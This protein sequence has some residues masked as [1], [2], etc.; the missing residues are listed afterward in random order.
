MAARST[1]PARARD[2][3]LGLPSSTD[4]H[5]PGS[6]AAMA[7]DQTRQALGIARRAPGHDER[8]RTALTSRSD[9]GVDVWTLSISSVSGAPEEV[10]P[11]TL[12]WHE[13]L[14]DG[15]AVWTTA[16]GRNK[17]L[18]PEW[19]PAS[20][21]VSKA[22]AQ[23][24]IACLVSGDGTSRVCI[25]SSDALYETK[26]EVGVLE[27]TAELRCRLTLFLPPHGRRAEA[28]VEVRIDRRPQRYE[29]ALAAVAEWWESLPGYAPTPVP[30]VA[31][32]PMYSTW[33]SF[34]QT[35]D[36][37]QDEEQCRL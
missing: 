12:E 30:D 26:L 20:A 17:G 4:A 11:L 28:K 16:A 2:L 3:D 13:P 14:V 25:A 9:G 34:H 37:P 7:T 29:R 6:L 23:A 35:L 8:F 19:G 33:Y 22:T 31:R 32:L 27:E 24:P 10:Q 5:L 36:P 21:V 1:T 18:P 15:A